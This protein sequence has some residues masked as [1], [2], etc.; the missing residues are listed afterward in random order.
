M[1]RKK[2]YRKWYKCP[3]RNGLLVPY[4]TCRQ[5]ENINTCKAESVERRV[6]VKAGD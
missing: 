3:E 5:C 6:W 1:A 2:A 4:D